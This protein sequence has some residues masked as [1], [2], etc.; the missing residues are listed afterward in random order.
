MTNADPHFLSYLV[1]SCITIGMS[2]FTV[3]SVIFYGVKLFTMSGMQ[4]VIYTVEYK[5][6]KSLCCNQWLFAAYYHD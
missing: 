2:G 1:L 4:L 3:Q 5:V 6:V